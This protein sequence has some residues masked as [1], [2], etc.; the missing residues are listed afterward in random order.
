[1][2][3]E[4]PTVHDGTVQLIT[5]GTYTPEFHSSQ[6][7]KTYICSEGLEK[8]PEHTT[9]RHLAVIPTVAVHIE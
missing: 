8:Y 9:P 5:L 2:V 7:M 3:V 1:M 4:V 6:N